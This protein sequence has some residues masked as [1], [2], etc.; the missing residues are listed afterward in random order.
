[1]SVVHLTRAAPGATIARIDYPYNPA[2]TD[3]VRR[4]P[5]R[6]F[7]RTYKV[8]LIPLTPDNVLLLREGVTALGWLLSIPRDVAD[9]LNKAYAK[10]KAAAAVRAAGDSDIAFDFVTE[11]YAHQ[12]A[13]L[14]FLAHLNGGALLWEMG[15]GKTKTAIDFAEYLSGP[16]RM[17]RPVLMRS[18]G[19]RVLVICPNTV[20]R[21]WGDEIR[22]HA[23][24]DDYVIPTGTIAKRITQLRSARYTI[25]NCEALSHKPM[26]DALRTAGPWDLVIVDEST[27]FKSPDVARTKALWKIPTRR[28]VILTGTPITGKPEDAFSQFEWVAP[29]TFGKSHWAFKE[30]YLEKDW[31]GNVTGIKPGMADEL[32]ERID[33]S[34]YRILKEDVLDLPE[35]VYVDRRVEMTGEQRRAYNQMRDELRIELADADEV[36]ASNILTVLLRLTQVTAGMVGERGR[37]QWLDKG[38]K[39]NELDDLLNDELRGEQ[40]V[41]FGLYQFEL[42]QLAIRYTREAEV[43]QSGIIYGPTPEWQRHEA[44]A[45]FQA[46]QR[47]L[48]FA[49]VRTGGIG[50]NLTAAQT[51]IYVTRSWSLEEYLQS[52]DRLH[53]IG[54]TGTVSIIHL[55]AEDSIDNDIAD[56]LKEKRNLAD[57]LTGD[58]ARALAARLLGK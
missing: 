33:R 28:R 36:R 30:R 38:A 5:G 22:K 53:R 45:Q 44:I 49:Q 18:D 54:Q 27:R 32:R 50:I 25:V 31:F 17:D 26:A 40:V 48:L 57:H 24:H 41:I 46:G 58:A 56:A 9:D 8:W 43:A 14:A 12:R 23:G 37:Y 2:V 29:G 21:N 55:L 42:E 16:E 20:K 35:K 6:E 47:R 1:M 52:Q 15:L 34:S 4:I 13:G 3:V 39:V 11:P 19:L 51:A 10:S 7:N